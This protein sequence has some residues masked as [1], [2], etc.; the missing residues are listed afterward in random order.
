MKDLLIGRTI[1]LVALIVTV[2]I[3]GLLA[4][5]RERR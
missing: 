5:L 1:V 2:A 4:A 3:I